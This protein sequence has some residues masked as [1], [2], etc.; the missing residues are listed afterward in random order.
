[1]PQFIIAL[2][3]GAGTE[4]TIRNGIRQLHR[5]RQRVGNGAHDD[6][7]RHQPQQRD[8][9]AGR[10]NQHIG[11]RTIGSALLN[12]L[13]LVVLLQ[14]HIG[15]QRRIVF[16]GQRVELFRNQLL[17]KLELLG[18]ASLIDLLVDRKQLVA[19]H[20]D[21]GHQALGLI[22]GDLRQHL[23]AQGVDAGNQPRH[24]LVLMLD[25][26]FFGGHGRRRKAV[27]AHLRQ[28]APL[29]RLCRCGLRT[30]NLGQSAFAD[31]I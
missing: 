3:R 26:I 27:H 16:F 17:R 28:D 15:I 5:L 6:Q 11:L 12:R 21:L 19:V 22:R 23:V 29:P 20:I 1:M 31:L 2:V 25:Q 14:L 30:R 18:P 7:P 13:R 9:C 8:E 4:I 24:Q 10:S